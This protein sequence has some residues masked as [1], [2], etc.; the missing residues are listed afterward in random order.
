MG[1]HQRKA[2]I[3]KI[4][5]TQFL[6]SW[7]VCFMF[8]NIIPQSSN[9][10]TAIVVCQADFL[11]NVNVNL[12]LKPDSIWKHTAEVF[13]TAQ[14]VGLSRT[15]SRVRFSHVE[16]LFNYLTKTACSSSVPIINFLPITEL[17]I[18]HHRLFRLSQKIHK[19]FI[20]S[21]PI[22]KLFITDILSVMATLWICIPITFAEVLI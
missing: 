13:T 16:Y 20:I 7:R 17:F 14:C 10:H 5:Y 1:Q 3:K 6:W 21:S 19:I 2:T 9:T 18:V 22:L 8:V 15:H 12:K 4:S 11:F